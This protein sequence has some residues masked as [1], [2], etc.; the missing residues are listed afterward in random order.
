MYLFELYDAQKNSYQDVEDDNSK[1]KWT[2]S[3][4]TRLTLAEI[5]KIRRMN[6]VRS[7][8]KAKDLARIRK[9]YSPPAQPAGI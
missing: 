4:K 1:P 3:R 2:E 5:N 7:Y 6:Q 9:Q 8:E